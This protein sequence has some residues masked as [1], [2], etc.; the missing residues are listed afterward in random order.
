MTGYSKN[1]I[2]GKSIYD[3]FDSESRKVLEKQAYTIRDTEHRTYDVKLLRKDGTN[4]PIKLQATTIRD[5]HGNITD[6]IAFIADVSDI[7][8]ATT[9]DALTGISNRGCFNSEL[10]ECYTLM[11]EGGLDE[12]SIAMIDIDHFKDINDKYGHPA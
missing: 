7:Y 5:T 12:I 1:E 6:I 4:L 11:K 10:K 3:F 9:K 8:E 2:I